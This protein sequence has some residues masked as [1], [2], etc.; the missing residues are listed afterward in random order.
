MNGTARCLIMCFIMAPLNCYSG[1]L[2]QNVYGYIELLTNS[3]KPTLAEYSKYAGECGGESELLFMQAECLNRY[4][5]IFSCDCVR[6]VKDRCDNQENVESLRLNWI[7]TK[8][9]TAGTIYEIKK[10]EDY[11]QSQPEEEITYNYKIIHV[12]IGDNIF[13]LYHSMESNLPLDLTTYISHINEKP[14]DLSFMVPD[15]NEKEKND[16]YD[17]IRNVDEI[18]KQENNISQ[19]LKSK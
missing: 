18:C 6:F 17:F 7:R 12:K 15:M 10:V 19:Q 2:L 3:N 11:N 14:L 8:F 13:K 5:A 9:L 4:K 16:A 1:E